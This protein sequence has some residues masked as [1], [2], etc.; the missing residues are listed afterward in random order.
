VNRLN[1]E[2]KTAASKRTG[3]GS[4]KSRHAGKLCEN[5]VYDRK[6]GRDDDQS[7][8]RVTNVGF[9]LFNF[10]GVAAGRHPE[11][12][13]VKQKS[14]QDDADKTES[15]INDTADD[16]KKICSPADTGLGSDDFKILLRSLC[17]NRKNK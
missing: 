3:A 15:D 7:D 13:R 2:A 11:I 6:R 5:E 8:D 9:C 4:A 17:K 10:C 12:A 14:E 16:G 1:P